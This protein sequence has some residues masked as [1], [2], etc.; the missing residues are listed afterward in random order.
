MVK[1]ESSKNISNDMSSA[2]SSSRDYGMDF[3]EEY[4]KK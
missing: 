2:Y 1:R 3:V 4:R